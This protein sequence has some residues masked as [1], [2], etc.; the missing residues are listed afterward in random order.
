MSLYDYRVP[1]NYTYGQLSKAV[2]NLDTTLV[3]PGFT[4]LPADLSTTRYLP[5]TLADDA[6]RRYETVWVVGHG[7]GSPNVT[8]VRGREATF[9]KRWATG[10]I[11]RCAPTAR[12]FLTV[13]DTMAGLP[14]DAHL[15]M[16]VTVADEWKTLEK[17]SDGWSVS[18]PHGGGRRQSWQQISGGITAN[19][20]PVITGWVPFPNNAD[21]ATL[22]PDGKLVLNQAGVWAFTFMTWGDGPAPRMSQATIRWVNG[23]WAPIFNE[24]TSVTQTGVGWAFAGTVTHNLNWT[25]YVTEDEANTP[26]DFVVS[27]HNATNFFVWANYYLTIELLGG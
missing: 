20:Y 17:V 26:I 15:G 4:T 22:A 8:V 23:A 10:S 18:A 7:G 16:R 21:I 25:G 5:I 1:A 2:T 27:N 14:A 13:A 11:W 3:S 9:A 6:A 24:L 19:T 12:D